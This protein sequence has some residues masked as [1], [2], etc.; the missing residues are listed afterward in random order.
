[1]QPAGRPRNVNPQ[2]LAAP[3]G[4][5]H[6]TVAGDTVWLGG[7]IGSDASGKVVEPGDVV[8]QFARAIGNV[9][10]A[11]RAAGCEPED[12]VKL[13]YYVTNL[14]LYRES[15]SAIGAAYREV[16][17]RHYPASTLIEVRSLFDPNALVEIDAV[18]VRR[19]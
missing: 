14:S 5:S 13:T 7:Q 11:L 18:A 19:P 12:T 6:A 16:F 2:E 15:L 17:G 3:T 1:M 9:A 4:F 8:A 10:I